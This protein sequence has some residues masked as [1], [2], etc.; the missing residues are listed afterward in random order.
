MKRDEK[1]SADAT[2]CRRLAHFYANKLCASRDVS[3][4]LAM[5][6]ALDSVVGREGNDNDRPEADSADQWAA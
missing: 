5:A 4:W 6:A 1:I 3:Y 2:M